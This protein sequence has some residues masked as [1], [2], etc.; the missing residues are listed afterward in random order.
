MSLREQ[1]FSGVR[2]T[3]FS[4]LGRALLQVVQIAILARLLT[5]ADFG[6]VAVVAALMAI[7]QIFS[8]AGV[9]NAI[10]HYQNVTATELSSL[11]WLNVGMSVLLGVLLA[12][13]SPWMSLWYHEPELRGLLIIAAF[14]LV[15][16]AL[17]QQ[18]RIVA[19]KNLRFAKLAKVELGAA[20]TGS[21]V[22]VAFAMRGGGAYS[23]ITGSLAAAASGTLLA[24]LYLAE[25]W[26]PALTMSAREIGK[27]L[28]FGVYMVGN[29]LANALNSQVDVLLG[30]RLLGARTIGLY[31]VPRDLSSRLAGVIN[32]IVTEVSLPVMAKT[33]ADRMLL[34]RLYLQ[35]MRMIA[36]VTFP[37][38]V[39]LAIFAGDVVSLLF[40]NQWE[41][42]VPLLRLLACWALLRSISNPVGSLLVA[43]G[44]P[45]LSFK[46][47]VALL[48]IVPPT[49]WIGSRSG[50]TGMATA[51]TILAALL[52]VPNWYFLVRPMCGAELGEYSKQVAVPFGLSLV[53]GLVGYIGAGPF[54]RDLAR[55]A[56][57][58]VVGGVVYVALSYSFNRTWVA[59]MR[60]LLVRA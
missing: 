20:L 48:L 30:G 36:S 49:V 4:S 51:M 16:G 34:K 22:A 6:L 45:D 28:R 5:P 47:N 50:V 55:L 24:W 2:W 46:W 25:G 57:G 1:A 23:L 53:A 29:N 37:I 8:D 11:Y 58:G 18:A 44:R 39:V 3:S 43:L 52:Y 21:V 12:L 26:R 10:I 31:S 59:A 13:L 27:F 38:Y 41:A 7:L 9:S 40:G 54:V 15:V 60:E 14:T 19:Q 35:V 56:A 33:Q 17:G 42:A 32:P